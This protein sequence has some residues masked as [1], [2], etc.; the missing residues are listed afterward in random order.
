[1]NRKSVA[2]L[3]CRVSTDMQREKENIETQKSRLLLYCKEHDITY[4]STYEDNGFSAKDTQ[5]PALNNL[6]NDIKKGKVKSVIVTKVDRLTR[7]IK[8]LI[9]LLELFDDHNVSFKSITQPLDTSTAL[10]R[11]FLRLIGEFAQME[12]EMVS[13]RVA[14]DMRHRAINGKWNGG[15][16]PFGYTSHSLIFNFLRKSGLNKE[17]AEVQA[18]KQVPEKKKL[19]INKAEANL[20][21]QIYEKYIETESLRATTHWLNRNGHRTRNGSTW[22]A[23]TVSRILTNPI[24]IGN[25]CYN[26]RVS[27]KTTKRLKRRPRKEWIENKGNHA[28]VIDKF[29]FDKVNEILL[30]QKQEPRRKTTKYLLSGLI[31]C[32]K[33]DGSMNGYT[34]T[35]KKNNLTY[36]Y[37]KCHTYSSKGSSVCKGSSI[38]ADLLEKAIGEFL[39]T[40]FDKNSFKINL[41]KALERFNTMKDQDITPLQDER[42]RLE[43]RNQDVERK[44]RILL[45]NL[46]DSTVDKLTYKNRTEELNK[47]FEDNK[48]KIYSLD[49]K[50]NDLGTDCFSFKAVYET[51]NDF[52]MSWENA[53]FQTR[54]D[55]LRLIV[56][57][58]VVVNKR[59]FKIDLYFLPS[60]LSQNCLH[61]D[62]RAGIIPTRIRSAAAPYR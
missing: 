54:K 24:Y 51:I 59:K 17:K 16:V 57:K 50:I 29:I 10:G 25:I 41:E 37:Y 13:E 36:S 60:I 44:K 8:D 2:A 56:S 15:V 14:E 12:R 4:P 58:I 5:R 42:E 43:K 48:T 39:I 21:K 18:S 40:E 7:S 28:P 23:T 35:K 19:F 53:D 34:Q 31:R 55:L 49:S 52:K 6:I 46:E 62:A 47:E 33:C 22:A 1:M 9:D 20:I 3:Y 26:K 45:E 30:R 38:R 11:G 61:T 32:G 27:S